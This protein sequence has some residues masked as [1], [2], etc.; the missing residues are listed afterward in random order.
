MSGQF[1]HHIVVNN[2]LFITCYQASKRIISLT[3]N[4]HTAYKCCHMNIFKFKRNPNV[5]TAY[6]SQLITVVVNA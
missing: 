3:F 5:K 6:V 1:A 4:E 2:P